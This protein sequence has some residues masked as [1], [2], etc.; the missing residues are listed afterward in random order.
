MTED[1]LYFGSDYLEGAHERVL[2]RLIE[3]NRQ[4]AAGYGSDSHSE[5]AYDLIRQACDCPHATVHFFIGGTQTNST[6]IRALLRPYQGVLAPDTGHINVHEAG[7]IELGGHKVL[8]LPSHEGKLTAQA[9]EDWVTTFYADANHVHSVYPGMVYVSQP[10]ELGTLYS[11]AELEALST[12]CRRHQLPLF[13]DGARLA[14]ALASPSNDV[15]L[16]DLARLTYVFYIGGT[17]CGTLL[18]EAVVISNPSLLPHFFTVMC[19]PS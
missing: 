13:I 6:V 18:G 11:L 2:E 3:V 5:R 9:V 4:P 7:A 14:Y 17:K 8:P 15:S 10:T 19:R 12:V 16:A 1:Y